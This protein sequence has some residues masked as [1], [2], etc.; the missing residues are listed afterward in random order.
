[1][2]QR[3]PQ[4][5]ANLGTN[6]L[7]RLCV[8]TWLIGLPSCGGSTS[9]PT[10][11]PT[12]A[13]FV[14]AALPNPVTAVRCNPLC[15]GTSGATFPFSATMTITFQESAGVGGNV[16]SI[17][18]T[19]ATGTGSLPPL[20]YGSDVVIQR[21][22]TNHIAARGALSFPFTLVYSTGATGAANLVV[23]IS[24]QLSDDRGNQFTVTGQV[25]V[26]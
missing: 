25:S 13:M 9:T 26:I 10:P 14:V 8:I 17:T 3:R 16:N 6:M 19:P 4:P 20:T 23:N 24:A 1:M 5:A 12:Q 18:I 22:G 2:H 21:S 7:K 15:T 11:T